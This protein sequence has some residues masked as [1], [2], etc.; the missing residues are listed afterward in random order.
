MRRR[1]IYRIPLRQGYGGQEGAERRKGSA[2]EDGW[3]IETK[4]GDAEVGEVG[5]RGAEE[6]VDSGEI[7]FLNETEGVHGF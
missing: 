6:E 4:R 7:L 3:W 1:K 5:E 2:K